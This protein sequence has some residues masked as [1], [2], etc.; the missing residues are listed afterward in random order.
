MEIMDVPP[1][2][3]RPPGVPDPFETFKAGRRAALTALKLEGNGNGTYVTAAGLKVDFTV[4]EEQPAILGIGGVVPP[5][6]L[7]P[8]LRWLTAGGGFDADGKGNATIHGPGGPVVIDFTNWFDPR[9]T[10]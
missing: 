4:D 7:T 10:P 6:W 1:P 9:R 8:P 3:E 2:V 5:D